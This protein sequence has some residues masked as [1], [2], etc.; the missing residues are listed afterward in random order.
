M[1]SVGAVLDACVLVPASLRDTLLRAAEEDLYRVHWSEHILE[2]VRRTLVDRELAD[3]TGAER[4]VSTLRSYFPEAA[5]QGYEPIIASMPNRPGDRHVLAAAIVAGVQTI[6]TVNL[7]D[8]PSEALAPFGLEA[9][10]PDTFL[11]S[12]FDRHPD[13]LARILLEQA[14]ELRK[15]PVTVSDLLTRLAR[16]T[17]TFAQRVRDHLAAR[18]GN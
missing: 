8:F 5:V 6:V 18:G 16:H 17:P 1:A 14:A 9:Q 4:L 10:H 7:K 15:P 3:E 13:R 12:L 11:A 2:E